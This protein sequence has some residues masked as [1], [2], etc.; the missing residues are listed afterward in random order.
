MTTFED[1]ADAQGWN[2][3]SREMVL[4]DFIGTRPNGGDLVAYAQ[5]RAD[6]ENQRKRVP[7][8]VITVTGQ[9]GGG[10]GWSSG[11][12]YQV[13]LAELDTGEDFGLV[14]ED[15]SGDVVNSMAL[16]V[17]LVVGI[18]AMTTIDHNINTA[19]E[20]WVL[21]EGMRRILVWDVGDFENVV[22]L[23]Q[24]KIEEI[25]E[26]LVYAVGDKEW[27]WDEQGEEWSY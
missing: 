19:E 13:T 14:V 17:D 9:Y 21:P 7:D 27:D 10:H 1:I 22:V 4:K 24:A 26:W 2:A 16:T 18:R 12:V 6:E 23:N 20:D 3:D 5:K 15:A 25:A 11:C 8:L